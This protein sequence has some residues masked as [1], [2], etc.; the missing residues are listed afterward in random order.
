MKK[1]TGQVMPL[2]ELPVGSA[3]VVVGLQESM[4]GVKKFA[5]AGMVPGAELFMQSHAPLGSLLRIKL[6]GCSLALHK[7]EGRCIMVRVN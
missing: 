6:L 2:A 7:N 3:G 5:D 1:C 4:R